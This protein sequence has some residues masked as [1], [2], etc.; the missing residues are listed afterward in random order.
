ML[1]VMRRPGVRVGL[2]IGQ[3]DPTFYC[4]STHRCTITVTNPTA[5]DW[6]YKGFWSIAPVFD[7]TLI[8][9]GQ[10]RSFYKD[11]TFGTAPGT[12]NSPVTID[13]QSTGQRWRFDFDPITLIE[14]AVPDVTATLTWD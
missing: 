10:T 2:G 4:G 1:E 7:W 12:Y 13:E 6:Y 3:G 14:E 5:W 9:A 11:I 8:G